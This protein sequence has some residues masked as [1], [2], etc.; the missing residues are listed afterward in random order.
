LAAESGGWRL[1]RKGRLRGL[2]RT[3]GV[4]GVDGKP[5]Q[6]GLVAQPL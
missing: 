3:P 5:R 1:R 2:E 4:P 6:A